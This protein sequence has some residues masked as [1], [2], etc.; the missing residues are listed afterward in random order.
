MVATLARLETVL[1]EQTG[2]GADKPD[3]TGDAG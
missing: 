3:G 1:A 2:D